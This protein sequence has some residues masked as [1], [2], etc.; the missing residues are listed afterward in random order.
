MLNLRSYVYSKQQCDHGCDYWEDIIC[1][2]GD[3]LKNSAERCT[4]CPSGRWNSDR[5]T[6]SVNG[7]KPCGPG[8]YGHS[9]GAQSEDS[10]TPC[11]KGKWSKSSGQSSDTCNDCPKGT[12]LALEG[13]TSQSAC[14]ECPEGRYNNAEGSPSEGNCVSTAAFP[15]K[16]SSHMRPLFDLMSADPAVPTAILH[17]TSIY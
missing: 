2:P 3:Y 4:P 1:V 10:C 16:R 11:T 13:K 7:C 17:T 8:K 12:Y 9:T 14:V 5:G 15:L 6:I